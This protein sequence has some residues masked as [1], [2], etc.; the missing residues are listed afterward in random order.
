MSNAE[1]AKIFRNIAAILQMKEVEWKPQA[2]RRAARSIDAMQEDA[3][4]V[5]KRSGLKGLEEIPGVGEALAKKIEQY[6]KEGR[7]KEYE[8]LQKTIPKPVV[9][10][11][12]IP[13]MGPKRAKILY[14]KLNIKS[15]KELAEAAE[16]HKLQK[17]R[18]FKQKTEENILKGIKILRTTKERTP[19]REVLPIANAILKK[20]KG[21]KGVKHAYVGG[22]VRRKEPTIGDLDFLVT[23]KNHTAV[24]ETFTKM[25]QVKE[26]LAKGETKAMVRLKNGMQSDLRVVPEE[27]FAAA[28]QYFTG[29][30][31]HNVKIR[32]IAIKKGY[33]LSEYG[34]FD[35]K[36]GKRIPCNTEHELYKKLGLRYIKPENRKNRGE[37]EKAMISYKNVVSVTK[38]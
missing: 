33:K 21:M 20:L 5:Y 27:S 9:E 23:T 19:I 3:A 10:M 2:Y 15:I 4:E 31:D 1:I 7:I 28:L 14:K 35:R 8:K 22:S 34:L 11:M 18:S 38:K 12:K 36:T 30:K 24:I 32:L 6:I 17:I 13:G 37:I 29:N 26:V 16:H 25:L